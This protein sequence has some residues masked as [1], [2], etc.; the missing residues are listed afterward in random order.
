MLSNTIVLFQSTERLDSIKE[1]EKEKFISELC[2]YESAQL[3][4]SRIVIG[5]LHIIQL[6]AYNSFL[7]RN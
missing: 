3:A 7:R 2:D 5:E 4:I 6:R 1:R